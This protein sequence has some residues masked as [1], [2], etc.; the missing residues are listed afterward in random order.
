MHKI[1]RL[2]SVISGLAL[3]VM[4]WITMIDVIGR[5]FLDHSLFGAVEF[6]EFM[7]MITIFF[8]MPL[9]SMAGEHIVFDLFDRFLSP[10][11]ALAQ[12]RLANALTALI[13]LGAAWIVFIRAQ[14]TLEFGDTTSQLEAPVA[15]FHFMMAASLV[16][17]ALVHAA[18]AWRKRG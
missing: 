1:R 14:R 8:A 5:K 12:R 18:F 15:P 9:T 4:M 10:G 6:T 3:F 16:L 2:L 13:M 11:A 7:M 17:A